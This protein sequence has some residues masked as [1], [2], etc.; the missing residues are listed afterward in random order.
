MSCITCREKQ[1]KFMN[2][3]A[4]EKMKVE[5]VDKI[6]F[7][8]SYFGILRHNCIICDKK[9]NS[10]YRI[11]ERDN[12][13]YDPANRYV[14]CDD[15]YYDLDIE[16][17]LNKIEGQLKYIE[18]NKDITVDYNDFKTLRNIELAIRRDKTYK[19]I[20]G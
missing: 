15:C 12:L 6:T 13:A 19:E 4:K 17:F 5:Y 14:M 3:I 18:N 10:C 16:T 7:L 8:W 11:V 1:L 2:D 9:A 20:I